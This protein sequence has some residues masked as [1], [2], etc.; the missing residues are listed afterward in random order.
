MGEKWLPS[1][2]HDVGDSL[3]LADGMSISG[4]ARPDQEATL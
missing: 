4:T 3:G 2:Q 1:G